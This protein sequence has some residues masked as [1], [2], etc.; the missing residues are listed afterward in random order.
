MNKIIGSPVKVEFDYAGGQIKGEFSPLTLLQE[1][2]LEMKSDANPRETVLHELELLA[3]N[4]KFLTYTDKDGEVIEFPTDKDG[5]IDLIS[6][7]PFALTFVKTLG[8]HYNN[9]NYDHF[10]KK[11]QPLND[12]PDGE[13][14]KDAVKSSPNKSDQ[15]DAE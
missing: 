2:D 10:I 13:E 9:G 15:R 6:Q 4:V 8:L 12:S 5:F 1:I 11:K 7:K 14:V 3:E